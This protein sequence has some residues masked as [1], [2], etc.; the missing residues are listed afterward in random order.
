MTREA[1]KER[2][3]SRTKGGKRGKSES[4]SNDPKFENKLAI[5]LN[6]TDGLNSQP[7]L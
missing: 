2:R 1:G 4:G 5:Y 6:Q 3:R 7:Y